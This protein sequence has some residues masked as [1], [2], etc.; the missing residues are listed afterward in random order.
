MSIA[1]DPSKIAAANVVLVTVKVSRA[2]RPGG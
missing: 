1:A 2:A